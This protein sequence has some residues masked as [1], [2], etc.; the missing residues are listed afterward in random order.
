MNAENLRTLARAIRTS[1]DLYNQQDWN[2]PGCG[3]PGCIAGFAEMCLLAEQ[4][5]PNW[6]YVRQPEIFE[7]LGLQ[8]EDAY[9]LFD[10][11][12]HEGD[13][14]WPAPFDGRY[15][16]ALAGAE[17]PAMVAA[18]LLDALADGTVSL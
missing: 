13:Y 16:A 5:R 15:A 6:T 2:N 18:D 10:G 11:A 9:V 7:W 12:P 14:H 8:R 4:G 3:T 1:P 17:P